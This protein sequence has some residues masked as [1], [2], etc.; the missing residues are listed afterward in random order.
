M[1]ANPFLIYILTFGSAIAIYQL[2]W[3]EIYPPTTRGLVLFFAFSFVVAGVAGWLVQPRVRSIRAYRAGLLPGWAVAVPLACF[4]ADLAY[5]GS[6]PLIDMIRGQFHYTSFKG[7]P[8]LHVFAVTFGSVFSTIRFADF[9]YETGRVR[10][11]YLGEAT[12]PIIFLLSIVYRGPALIV[13]TSWVFVFL[14]Y[15]PR[16]RV[17]HVVSMVALGTLLLFG[18]AKFGEA[19]SGNV[20]G[21]GHATEAFHGSNLGPVAFWL[22]LY[23]TGPLANFQY[24]VSTVKPPYDLKKI[25]EYA[26]SELLP[27]AISHRILPRLGVSPDRNIPEFSDNFNVSSVF[28]RSWIFFGWFSVLTTFAVFIFILYA[29]IGVIRTSPL[30]V[31]SL[32]LL[33]T[34]VVYNLFDNMIATTSIGIQ[35]VWPLLLGLLLKKRASFEAEPLRA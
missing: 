34:F 13:L 29:Y 31:P 28:S 21:L 17:S 19:R 33:N 12:L 16:I 5:A 8:S 18:A 25:P 3:S 32:A 27:D 1:L 22:F 30:A 24:A 11:R 23:S 9:L 26:V 14:I 4:A 20:N 7:M 15:L 2:G 6:V 35:I 10:W